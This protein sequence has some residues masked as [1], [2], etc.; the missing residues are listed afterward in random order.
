[1]RRNRILT[2]ALAGGLAACG[3]NGFNGGTASKGTSD[4]KPG[5][6]SPGDSGGSKTPG[7]SAGPGNLVTEPGGD[8]PANVDGGSVTV[9]EATPDERKAI[10]ACSTA[11]G[12]NAPVNFDSVRKI[13][14]SVSVLGSNT[15]V[16]NRRTEFPELTLILA[17]V[18]VLS[19][20]DWKLLNP[21]GWYCMVANVNVLSS[22]T[23]TINENGHL[24]DS[25]VAVDVL[26]KTDG[27]AAGA[28]V[29]VLSSVKVI[30]QADE[31]TDEGEDDD[32]ANASSDEES[33]D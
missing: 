5:Q 14:A 6:G 33:E 23:V 15:L 7:D 20:L 27:A 25:R 31:D 10:E 32:E 17:S 26:S 13:A 9:G 8:D 12:G 4:A 28:N 21:N 2:L 30:K 29:N 24:A 3:S 1:M 18:N 22:M 19:K 11:W 16:D